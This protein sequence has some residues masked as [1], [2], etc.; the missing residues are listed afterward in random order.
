MPNRPALEIF[1]QHR[2][3][4]L[5]ASVVA[6]LLLCLG[7]HA[8]ESAI[9]TAPPVTITLGQKMTFLPLLPETEARSEYPLTIR[10]EADEHGLYLVFDLEGA[11]LA[12]LSRIGSP[13][14]I[15]L[16][17]DLRNEAE[18]TT[19]TRATRFRV[20]GR[21]DEGQMA[22]ERTV[23]D[24]KGENLKTETKLDAEARLS[25]LRSGTPRVSLFLSRK[26]IGDHPWK[27]GEAGQSL[28]FDVFVHFADFDRSGALEL[29]DEG[30]EAEGSPKEELTAEL[31]EPGKQVYPDWHTFVMVRGLNNPHANTITTG[32]M[33]SLQLHNFSLGDLT[34]SLRAIGQ[35]KAKDDISRRAE[36]VALMTILNAEVRGGVLMACEHQDE[37][38]REG[39]KRVITSH[40]FGGVD[41]GVSVPRSGPDTAGQ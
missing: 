18:R 38:V 29:V 1:P 17:F 30:E 27:L 41:G 11:V 19:D 34:E 26:E 36:S 5:R 6:V 9:Q 25:F 20:V 4:M 28:P 31:G 2:T 35:T 32:S 8:Q 14:Y 3:R 13:F 22:V 39:A 21:F 37:S 16:H 12:E 23:S 40:A 7:V 15:D 33:N 10:A 24:A